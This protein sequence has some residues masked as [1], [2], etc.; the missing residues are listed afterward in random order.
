MR[1]GAAKMKRTRHCARRGGL[2]CCDAAPSR[3][4]RGADEGQ[5]ERRCD[6]A[7]RRENARGTACGAVDSPAATRR[8]AEA[9][10][11]RGWAASA[12]MRFGAATRQRTR[13]GARR[14]RLTSC[15]AAPRGG[16]G[17]RRRGSVNGDVIR[18]DDE[19]TH[20]ARRAVRATHHL[21]RGA[22]PGGEGGRRRDSVSGIVIWR[23]DEKTHEARRVARLTH[24]LRRGAERGRKEAEEGHRE[25]RCHQA[26]RRGNARGTARGAVDSPPA[27][28]CRAVAKG[29]GGGTS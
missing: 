29:G 25:G 10:G 13:H 2:T 28:R 27:T 5:R 15:D 12:A 23:G 6:M 26:R 3:A 16:G 21:G 22:E 24:E 14:G 4:G 1:H 20:E 8:R 19:E 17:R 9:R 11:G 18:R 7:R